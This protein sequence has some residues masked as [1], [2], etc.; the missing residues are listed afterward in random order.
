[1]VNTWG[2]NDFSSFYR[3]IHADPSGSQAKAVDNALEK[4]FHLSLFQAEDQYMNLLNQQPSNPDL[5]ILIRLTA[6]YYDTVRQ[7]QQILDPSAYFRQVWL[8]DVDT[9]VAKGI[10]A[11]YVQH[12]DST[13][14]LTIELLL[15]D[16]RQEMNSGDYARATQTIQAINQALDGLQPSTLLNVD[17]ASSDRQFKE[18]LVNNPLVSSMEGAVEAVQG[19]GLDPQSI[20]LG[21]QNGQAVVITTWPQSALLGL[22]HQQSWSADCPKETK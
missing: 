5:E 12:P 22:T 20:Q 16:A 21:N 6:S 7:Y 10:V 18:S 2:W 14:N 15:I 17:Q 9:M 4:H 19:C 8:L 3:D 11:D 13:A 1:M